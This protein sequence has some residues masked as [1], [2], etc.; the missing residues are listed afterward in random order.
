MRPRLV[1]A[2]LEQDMDEVSDGEEGKAEEREDL[3]KINIPHHNWP[4]HAFKS[5]KS[6]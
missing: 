1:E 4:K 5:G 2:I 6:F 3:D